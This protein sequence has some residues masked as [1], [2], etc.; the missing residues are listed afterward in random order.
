M[1]DRQPKPYF[2]ADFSEDIAQED[3]AARNLEELG[4]TLVPA[5]RILSAAIG[6]KTNPA[7]LNSVVSRQLP[8][9]IRSDGR[10]IGVRGA[11]SR[12]LIGLAQNDPQVLFPA[13]T[14][15]GRE[16]MVYML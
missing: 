15:Q 2:F 1:K 13:L 8:G 12:R 3:E 4:D 7:K 9:L 6:V 14:K 10:R 5:C 11:D 16:T